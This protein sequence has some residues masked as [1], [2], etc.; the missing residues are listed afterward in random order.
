MKRRVEQSLR[1]FIPAALHFSTLF[2]VLRIYEWM[3]LNNRMGKE[4]NVTFLTFSALAYDLIFAFLLV[5]YVLAFHL[6]ITIILP[7][8]AYTLSVIAFTVLLL[9]TFVTVQYFSITFTPLSTDLLGYSLADMI[10]T[11]GS[12]G[13]WQWYPI[14]AL[15]VLLTIAIAIFIKFSHDFFEKKSFAF[16]IGISSLF[17]IAWLLPHAAVPEKFQRD[18]EYYISVNKTYYFLERTIDYVQDFTTSEIQENDFPLLHPI[19]YEDGFAKL[20]NKSED[21]PNFVFVIV[22]G[23]GR[24]FTGSDAAYGGFTPFL[25]SLS[26]KS[27]HW[28]NF[29][30]NAGRTFGALPSI[31]GSL[32]YA[33]EGFMSYG[34]DM[35]DHQ[36][37]ISL[38]KPYDYTANF[39]YGGNPNFD[40]QDI[41]L[42]YQGFDNMLDQTK[43]PNSFEDEVSSWGYSDREV[44]SLAAKLLD[45]K[46]GPR[47]DVYL[48]LSTHEPFN[49][50]D[51]A[52]DS[53][54]E[55]RL[56]QLQWSEEKYSVARDHKS[57]FSCLLYTDQAIRDLIRYYE[58]R[59]DFKNTILVITGDHRLV[60]LPPHEKID[61]F[62]VP[63]IIYSPLLSQPESFSSLAIHSD[64]TPSLLNLLSSDYGLRFPEQMPFISGPLS[65]DTKFS[66]N[67]DLALIR[68]KNETIDYVEGNYF[69]SG[70]RLYKIHPNMELEPLQDSDIKKRL[71]KKLKV[72]KAN[73]L[74]ACN[75]N[76]LDKRPPTHRISLQTTK[77]EQ[78][79]IESQALVRLTPDEMFEKARSLSLTKN[80]FESRAILKSLLNKSPNFHDA[81]ILLART[82]GWSQKYDSAKLYISQ[83]LQRA[84]T[85]AD[86]FA[87]WADIEY[88]QEHHAEC[89]EIVEK[90]LSH[91]P[92][93]EELMSRKARVLLLLNRK[94]EARRIL[95]DILRL[96]PDQEMALELVQKINKQ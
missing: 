92:L 51:R 2:L 65:T 7:R 74:Y 73:T 82:Y 35:P 89:L 50:P 53:I 10:T 66:S 56:K 28:N 14:I 67:L 44:F 54:F 81:R 16:V 24:D 19:N 15:V 39:F 29:L 37:F 80:Y 20:F 86:A 4:I 13:G 72:F 25:D 34:T 94:E 38:L 79:F 9:L 47:I 87:A 84:P 85:Y 70:E 48:T 93:N 69:L 8:I 30:S 91:H 11:V 46:V 68:N 40:N 5:S 33:R 76:Q 36:T 55:Q 75:N 90:G 61:R 63:L 1:Q 52:Y 22:E 17:M 64:I 27:L 49:V 23:L 3:L 62:H 83:T 12:S 26:E 95:D 43:S 21:Y 32:P 31:L 41:F 57:I 58:S 45:N 42:E 18:I 71:V 6:V 77:A 59:D 78:D 60:P 88:W 96:H